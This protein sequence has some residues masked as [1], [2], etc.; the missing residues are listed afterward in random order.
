VNLTA[1][2]TVLSA[3]CEHPARLQSSPHRL[4]ARFPRR[5]AR[6]AAAFSFL[7][8]A[9]MAPLH[10]DPASDLFEAYEH[11]ILG[12]AATATGMTV[13][14]SNLT[15]QF[16]SGAVAPVLAAGERIGI[17]FRGEGRFTYQSIDPLESG[18]VLFEAKKLDRDAKKNADGSV[19]VSGKFERLYLQA[20]GV[21]LPELP[22][23]EAG[24]GAL[25][26]AFREHR[27]EFGNTRWTP[28]SH[29][30]IRQ[31]LD[32]PN[33]RVAVAQF[34]G[35]GRYGYVLDTI[36]SHDERLYALITQSGLFDYPE[37][38]GALFPVTISEQPVGRK[39]GD[40][41]QPR[42]LLVD[43]DY[44]LVAGEKA[45]AKLSVT[46]T[47]L[48]R[49]L[50][51]SVFRFDLLT[52]VWDSDGKYRRYRIDSVT[53]ASGAKLPYHFDHNSVLVRMPSKLPADEPAVIRFEISGDF[54]F[55]PD[56]VNNAL[57][58]IAQRVN[59]NAE[60]G[61]VSAQGIYLQF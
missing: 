25:L 31:K 15:L 6:V 40:F 29:L 2:T 43:L 16:D 48:P 34:S 61:A 46:E 57:L 35:S 54:L 53:D 23:A 52:G 45:E 3:A 21:V 9:P 49:K 27:E 42:Y 41:V 22:A 36:E 44:T 12:L 7:L 60:F 37:L 39:R 18:I 33:A 47:L 51:Q 38:R 19:T 4:A 50:P 14:V 55:R 24:R 20:G 17:F 58:F 56:N 5:L 8:L 32:E 28:P 59:A 11:P 10:A 30:L 26:D 13:K 1:I